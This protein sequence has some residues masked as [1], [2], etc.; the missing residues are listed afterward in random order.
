MLSRLSANVLLK[1]VIAVMATAIVFLLA[2][3]AWSSWQRYASASR[4]AGVAH[5]SRFAFTVMHNLRT[6]RSSTVRALNTPGPVEAE[7]KSYLKGL[8][9]SEMPALAG[10]ISSLQTIEFAD[11]GTL[12][13]SLQSAQ[14]KL[15]Q[16]QSESWA[17]FEKPKADRRAQ[18]A[19]E[20]DSEE[21]GMLELLDKIAARLVALVKHDDPFIDQMLQMKQTAWML[22]NTAGEASLIVS[23]GL[24]KGS[25]PAEAPAKYAGFVGGS[26]ALWDVLEDMAS[27]RPVPQRLAKAMAEAKTAYFAPEYTAT[28]DRILSTLVKGEKPE[29]TANQWSPYTVGRLAA[30][31]AVAEAALDAAKDHAATQQSAAAWELGTQ[32]GLLIIALTFA[33][34]LMSTVSRR[35]IRPLHQ[36]QDAML[37][38][39]SGDLSAEAAFPG[40]TDEI[41]ALAGALGTFKQNAAEK[42]RIEEEQKDRNAQRAKRQEAIEGYIKSF[43]GQVREAL[44]A[45][46]TASGQM[47]TTSDGI[48]KTAERST[49]QVQAVA[50]A[51]EEA[52]ANV[53]T[54]A[55][56]SEQL[57]GSIAE[58]SQQVAR[59]ANIAGRAVEETKQTDGTVQGLVEAAARIGEVVKLINDIA[60]QTN[61][62]AL[63]ATIE[64]ARAGEALA[65]FAVVASEVKSLANQTAKA[66]E[67]ISAQITAVQ[68]VTKDAVEAIKRIGGTIGEVSSVATSIASAVEEQ[69]AA[70]KE[71]TRNTHEAAQRTKDVSKTIV[72]VRE[73]ANATGSAAQGVKSAAGAL[74]ERA[75]QLRTQV[76]DFLAKMRAA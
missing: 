70:T 57:S 58:I 9:D 64:A 75:E 37:K 1:S 43:E 66:T 15:I 49:T 16:L 52:S 60:G 20:Y 39:A 4:I 44:E 17:A 22:R 65:R 55:A 19:T 6:D 71:I 47:L 53:Q 40:R 25:V 30:V 67:D 42:A 26:I 14:A 41:G 38:V 21:T 73:G 72:D 56:A 76:N 51:S 35:V 5:A 3:G 10:A 28:R 45:L 12:L 54:V 33:L 7:L 46:G 2:L 62:L 61:L 31:V 69:G 34:G 36:I 29:M 11:R 59:A 68:N 32:L 63:N 48:S 8:R 50:S 24:A 13:P 18:L 74:R 23:T 27:G